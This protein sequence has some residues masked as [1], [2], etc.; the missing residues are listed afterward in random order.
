[1][2]EHKGRV[3]NMAPCYVIFLALEKNIYDVPERFLVQE[4]RTFPWPALAGWDYHPEEHRNLPPTGLPSSVQTLAAS[5]SAS[6]SGFGA[7]SRR[8]F[9]NGW[10]K[11][12]PA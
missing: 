1:V 10:Y 3:A 4:I 9:K 6:S 8:R 5:G 11:I 12:T 2:E 7:E